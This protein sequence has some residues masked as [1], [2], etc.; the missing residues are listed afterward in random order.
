[1]AR[2]SHHNGI[3]TQGQQDHDK[4][5]RQ[6]NTGLFATL[7]REEFIPPHDIAKARLPKAPI[8]QIVPFTESELRAVFS[9]IG[10]KGPFSARNRAMVLLLLDPGLRV[11]EACGLTDDGVDL[12]EMQITVS[13]KGGKDRVLPLSRWATKALLV[14]KVRART[15]PVGCDNFFLTKEGLPVT[16]SAV[17]QMLIRVGNRANVRGVSPHRFRHSFAL[18]FLRNGGDSFHLQRLLGHSTLEMTRR[19]TRLADVDIKEAHRKFSP[20]DRLRL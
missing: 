18:L 1:M 11:S 3:K 5:L 19:Y 8:K 14:Y 15:E 2:S 9:A 13:G 7:E 16:R 17:E 12:S 10:T 6:G 4:H 20:S